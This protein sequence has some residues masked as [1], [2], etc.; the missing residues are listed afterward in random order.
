MNLTIESKFISIFK[1]ITGFDYIN[2]NNQIETDDDYETFLAENYLNHIYVIDDYELKY[3]FAT[4]FKKSIFQRNLLNKFGYIC[5]ILSVSNYIFPRLKN[6]L[7]FNL[8]EIVV[9]KILTIQ[10]TDLDN[11]SETEL[12]DFLIEKRLELFELSIKIYNLMT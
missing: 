3:V 1:N 4:I 11:F 5:E 7:A 10:K 2:Y 12:V 9:K 6:I 8:V